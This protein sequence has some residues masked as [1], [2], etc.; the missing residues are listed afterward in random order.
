[1][2]PA[3][4]PL[5]YKTLYEIPGFADMR[6]VA[7]SLRVELMIHGGFVRRLAAAFR[8]SENSIPCPEDLAFFS[9]DIDVVHSGSV[10]QT[11]AVSDALV[12]AIPFGE[13]I[14]WQIKSAEEFQIFEAAMPFNGIVPAN[15]LSIATSPDWGI[16]DEWQGQFDIQQ[17]KYRYIR[18]GYYKRSPL[19]KA[20]R[21]LELFSALLYFKALVDDQISSNELPNQPGIKDAKTVV[22]SACSSPTMLTAL[23]ESSYLRARLL[24]LMKDIR[25]AVLSSFEWRK[26]MTEFGIDRLVEYLKADAMFNL[27]DQL[28]ELVSKN[29]TVTISARLGGDRY[30]FRDATEPW[31]S[32]A[33][34]MKQFEATLARYSNSPD[35]EEIPQLGPGQSIAFSSPTLPINQGQ[36]SSSRTGKT[37]QEFFHFAVT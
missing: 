7:E 6:D 33:Q 28:E 20:G 25:V 18:N 16:K 21:D 32:G 9:S 5:P 36:S 14:R 34:A 37:V 17:R 11:A 1:M 26:Q 24:Y 12:E 19:L 4:G 2:P 31:Q 35:D 8:Q 13:C 15:L 3:R 23:E 30:R 27:G 29:Q 22:H 10:E